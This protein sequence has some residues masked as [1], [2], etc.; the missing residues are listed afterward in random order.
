MLKLKEFFI[1]IFITVI[2]LGLRIYN[3]DFNFSVIVSTLSVVLLFFLS[4]QIFIKQNKGSTIAILSSLFL[5]LNPWH[6]YLSQ[7]QP[8]AAL[9]IFLFLLFGLVFL[10]FLNRLIKNSK[11]ISLFKIAFFLLVLL[12]I[13]GLCSFKPFFSDSELWAEY[14]REKMQGLNVFWA[15]ALFHNLLLFYGREFVNNFLFYFTPEF[16][17]LPN[18]IN[19]ISRFYLW[20]G[21]FMITGLVGHLQAKSM[22]KRLLLVCLFMIILTA[23]LFRRDAFLPIAVI[24]PVWQLI[25]ASGM[26]EFFSKTGKK[27]RISGTVLLVFVVI[28]EFLTFFNL[29]YFH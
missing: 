5:G 16:L 26:V 24:I 3:H 13:V 19:N 6:I 2:S 14:E 12:L 1:L 4:R 17:F 28:L 10:I 27:A 8:K 11:K 29:Y 22:R 9:M 7:N 18:S 21:I 15:Q 25:T 23:S 20:E